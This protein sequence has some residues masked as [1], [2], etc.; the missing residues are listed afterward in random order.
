MGR[1]SVMGFIAPLVIFLAFNLVIARA[2]LAAPV[3]ISARVACEAALAQ[4]AGG[5]GTAS[6]RV[7]CHSAFIVDGGLEDMRNEVASLMSPRAHPSLDDLV[8]GSLIADAAMR[9]APDQP[10]GYFARCDI[11]RR[12]GSADVLE[13][14]LADLRRVAP[15]HAATK[16]AL[17]NAGERAPIG[18]WIFRVLL[19]LGFLGTLVHALLRRRRTARPLVTPAKLAATLVLGI[20]SL[21]GLG[22]GVAWAEPMPT[23]DQLS[24]F[25]IDDA[26]PEASVPSQESQDKKPLEFGYYL[27]DLAA[28]AERAAKVGDHAAEAR[29][30]AALAKAAPTAAYGPRKQCA[31]LE[32]AGDIPNAVV[33]CRNTLTRQGST[34][35][36]YVHFVH[37]VLATRGPLPP[38]EQKELQAVIAHLAG[39]AK[40]GALPAM[41]RCEVAL[42]F[43]DTAALEACATELGKTAPNDP[44]T[45][46]FQWALALAKND[47]TAA[48]QLVDRARGVG[49]GSDGIA[50]MEQAVHRMSRR[51]LERFGRLAVTAALAALALAL[52]FRHLAQRRRL[53]V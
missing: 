8:L 34:A 52:A 39:E 47:R 49:I 28:K 51:R 2:A 50:K 17:A 45:V 48:L 19:S 41:L 29:Y 7:P 25:H 53:A 1:L 4:E 30:Y 37:V 21:M 11:A 35:S 15:E 31:A 36:D 27:Q 38:L 32:T 33:A 40:L 46:S 13:A 3:G 9:K 22:T 12:L 16:K 44:K 43:S 26:D 23:G 18:V 20:V 14:C 6:S 42:R 10:W 5:Q 24:K